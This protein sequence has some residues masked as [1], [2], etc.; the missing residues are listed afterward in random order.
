[1]KK[2]LTVLIILAALLLLSTVT[3]ASAKETEKDL[4]EWL[5]SR[6]IQCDNIVGYQA[7]FLDEDVYRLSKRDL[8]D[9][10]II[11]DEGNF[12]PYYL[13]NEYLSTE[14]DSGMEYDSVKLYSY[15]KR[16]DHYSEFMVI[17]KDALHDILTNEIF[18][19]IKNDNF[20]E[21]VKIYGGY[22]GNTW[23]HIKSDYIYRTDEGKKLSIK[24]E[25]TLK[26][27]H[28][29]IVFVNDV[30]KTEINDLIFI[31][32]EKNVIHEYYQKMKTGIISVESVDNHT[33]II[34]ENK[35]NL[36]IK[37]MNIISDDSFKRKY[38][39]YYKNEEDMDY[40]ILDSGE[41]YQM[42]L[43]NFNIKETEI[44]CGKTS[45]LFLSADWIKIRVNDNDDQPIYIESLEVTYYIDKIVFENQGSDNY[46]LLFG[47][48]NTQRASYDIAQSKKYIEEEEQQIC[49]LLELMERE[50]EV[51]EEPFNYRMILNV[52]VVLVSI[53]LLLII[54]RKSGFKKL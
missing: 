16:D 3:I 42:N 12:V 34:F 31:Y 10:R 48:E 41:L 35:D 54:T 6:D 25:D 33:E 20:L 30:E 44:T 11:D 40:Q 23:E 15:L 18:F 5:Y 49:T 1:M 24:L 46:T 7:I 39:L 51:A 38:Q 53:I 52:I 21:E 2:K 50:V 13:H 26:F 8:S 4:N 27:D 43:E 17:E 45:D 14:K 36:K 9:I 37:S 32:S 22:D 19:D 28:Y 47:S 29:R